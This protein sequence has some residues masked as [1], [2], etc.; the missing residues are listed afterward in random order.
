M[1]MVEFIQGLNVKF[2]DEDRDCCL[3]AVEKI[4]ELAELARRNGMLI[5]DTLA[6]DE[7]D[8]FLKTAFTMMADGHSKE[9]ICETL[10]LLILGSGSDR[11][12]PT[13][14]SLFHYLLLTEGI[15]RITAGDNPRIIRDH[16]IAMLGDKHVLRADEIEAKYEKKQE[17]I[18]AFWDD[19]EKR[20]E[21]EELPEF[22]SLIIRMYDNYLRKMRD[23]IPEKRLAT[24]LKGVTNRDVWRRIFG[25]ISTGSKLQ[26]IETFNNLPEVS[27]A[28]IASAQAEV[29]EYIKALNN[30]KRGIFWKD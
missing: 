2:E 4:Y 27:D 14:A 30:A 17:I 18:N 15:L 6:Q 21:Q 16:L 26:L 28:D 10:Q 12:A 20:A 24:A 8:A 22:E 11:I 23:Y 29:V 9:D 1:D 7:Q 13:G 5:F 25:I 3:P 19:L